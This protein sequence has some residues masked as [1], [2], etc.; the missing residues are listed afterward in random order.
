MY[1][2][3]CEKY[4]RDDVK[5]NY[6]LDERYPYACDF[7]IVSEDKFIEFQGHWTHGKKP[8]KPEEKDSQEKLNKWK[9]KAK[10]SKFY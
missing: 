5:R 7:Y 6:D 8:F 10:T 3:L 9:E 2:Q 4:R 1:N